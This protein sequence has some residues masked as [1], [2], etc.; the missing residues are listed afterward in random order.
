MWILQKKESTTGVRRMKKLILN[1]CQFGLL[2]VLK[3]V[4][5]APRNNTWKCRCSCGTTLNVKQDNL[6][7]GY[8]KHCGCA[9]ANNPR[10]TWKKKVGSPPLPV[11]K[12]QMGPGIE[13]IGPFS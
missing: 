7:R 8:T 2:T 11:L 12:N 6:T 1:N 5:E 3:M 13:S 9:H 4:R 10:T